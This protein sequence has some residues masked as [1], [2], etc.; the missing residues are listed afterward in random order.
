MKSIIGKSNQSSPD[1]AV[2]EATGNL[3]NPSLI[4]FIAPYER[5]SRTAELI[6]E[7]YA[8]IPSIGTLGTTLVNGVV[9]ESETIVIGLHDIVVSADLIERLSQ[10]PVSHISH[11]EKNIKAVSPNKENTVCF[12]FCTGEEER[13]VTTL[14][15]GLERYKISLVGG[16]VFGQP[17]GVASVVA[18]NGKLYEDA[19]CY[20]I[21]KN[22]TGKVK[23]YKEN[24]YEN[25]NNIFHYAT[26]VNLNTKGL[27]QLDHR[28]AHE[29]YSEELGIPKDKIIDNVLVNPMGRAVG[30]EVFISS[31]REMTPDGTINN[32]KRINEN[33][34][35]CFLSLMDYE[36]VGKRTRERIIKEFRN[37]S[38]V[39]SFDCIY[40]YVLFDKKGYINKH[41]TNMA[42][43][44]PH[45]GIIGGGEQ[46]N[47]Q[48]VNQTMVC[49]VFE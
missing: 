47:N 24:I 41:A 40:R 20:A 37:V 9:S 23:V 13:L 31:M 18:Y 19:C 3:S 38:L 2:I 48:H 35:I 42:S 34:T 17:D 7:K 36:E 28:P 27:I 22:T 25:K 16:T 30:D 10:C 49:A 26:K 12:E 14:N 32:F 29:V 15:A 45:V 6:H 39:L 44:G 1:A 21:V 8:N 11:L 43:L 4:I 33:D 46:Y 5:L